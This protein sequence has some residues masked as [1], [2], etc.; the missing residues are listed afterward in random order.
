MA[1]ATDSKSVAKHGVWVQV[2]LPASRVVRFYWSNIIVADGRKK[3][4]LNLMAKHI[5]T[6]E[7]PDMQLGCSR[8][9][10]ASCIY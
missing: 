6:D 8:T 5:A 9:V 2:P 4:D 1:D 10:D 7:R 3:A